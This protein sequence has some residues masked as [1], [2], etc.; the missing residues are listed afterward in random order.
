[1]GCKKGVEVYKQWV[2]T[3]IFTA[4]FTASD[5]TTSAQPIL[6]RPLVVQAANQR[7]Y[8]VIIGTGRYFV[9]G[10]RADTDVQSMYGIWDRL[11]DDL[12]LKSKLVQQAYTNQCEAVTGD[13]GVTTTTC[14]RTLSDDSVDLY[15]SD[16]E[17]V[18][19]SVLGWFNDLN[20]AAGGDI[21]AS[22]GERAVRNFQI[23]GGLGFVN[24][25]LPTTST[26][27]SASSG[28]FGLAFCPLTGGSS[29]LQDGVF[30]LNNDGSFDASDLIN[31]AIVA[32]TVFEGSAPTDAA[33]VGENRVTQL[34]DRS[35]SIVRTNTETSINTGR[36]SWRRLSND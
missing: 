29:C 8:I 33:F 35:L 30:D 3:K 11:G 19:P 26:A 31:G 23:R 14:G 27:C 6:N 5:G 9:N 10:D 32:G 34:S 28:G 36:L 16:D 24:S 1:G 17:S 15:V 21:A 18:T 20:V 25:V 13:G 7:G 2:S 12:V 4:S 22:S